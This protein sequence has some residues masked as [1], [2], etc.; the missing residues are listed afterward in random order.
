MKIA[1]NCIN[2]TWVAQGGPFVEAHVAFRVLTRV[3]RSYHKVFKSQTVAE[4][5]HYSAARWL[6]CTLA[7]M[8]ISI[9][10]T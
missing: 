9:I 4:I 6:S 7:R 3:L 1:Y 5:L 10:F 8:P 2:I